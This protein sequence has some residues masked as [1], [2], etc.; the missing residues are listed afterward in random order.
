MQGRSIRSL[1]LDY[2][3]KRGADIR[4]LD[5]AESYE[6]VQ[7][8]GQN[9]KVTFTDDAVNGGQVMPL[10]ATSPQWRAIL[11]DLTAEVAVSYRYLVAGPIAK[12]AT[13]LEAA[14]PPGWR[15]LAAKLQHVDHRAALGVTHR[16]TFDSPAL[17]ACQELMFQHLWDV[18]REERLTTLEPLLYTA[19]CVLLRPEH[20]PGA[21]TVQ[22][23]VDRSATIVDVEAE[24]HGVQLEKELAGLLAETE[25]RINAY[26]DQQMGNVLARE[27]ALTEKLDNTIKKLGEAKTP[28]AMTRYRQD[29]QS[30]E[31]QLSHL[32]ANRERDLQAV[33][34]ACLAKLDQERERHE[35]TA[36]IDLVALCHATYDVLTYRATLESPEGR[37]IDLSV[38]YWPLTRA[39]AFPDCPACRHPMEEPAILSDGQAVCGHCTSECAGCGALHDA[40]TFVAGECA[41]C[42]EALCNACEI[43]CVGCGSVACGAHASECATCEAPVCAGC[44]QTC[45]TCQTSLCG[46]HTLTVGTAAYCAEHHDAAVAAAEALAAVTAPV[47]ATP[48]PEAPVAVEPIAEAPVPTPA[49]QPTMVKAF[50]ES[51]RVVSQL[52]GKTINPRVAEPCYAC[53][54]HFDVQEMHNCG[55]CGVPSCLPCT[56]GELGPCPACANLEDV[57]SNDGRLSFVIESFPALAKRRRWAVSEMGPYV[58]THWKRFGHWG[59]VV[60]HTGSEPVVLTEFAYGPVETLAMTLGSWFLPRRR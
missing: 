39:L 60:Y 33:E 54:G 25:K 4:P 52:S 31:A 37:V 1:A 30:L 29:G 53:A 3:R 14:M 59:M 21:S 38:R 15:V 51:E 42:A 56:E 17:N 55:T 46:T 18:D 23:L 43:P 5:G 49:P 41:G 9:L 10:T 13:V 40:R 7:A 36:T 24:S 35:L 26:Y 22:A 32:K 58:V 45:A 19:P 57:P 20:M 11:E 27:V 34:S 28:D 2:Y 47:V 6:I 12:P 48:E 8:E 50:G 44:T 16:A